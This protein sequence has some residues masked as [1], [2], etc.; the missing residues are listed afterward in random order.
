V[1]TDTG[2]VEQTIAFSGSYV[3]DDGHI[4]VSRA[5][6]DAHQYS[7]DRFVGTCDVC[8]RAGLLPASGELLADV[9]AVNRFVATH[10]HGDTD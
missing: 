6:P 3:S 5:Q 4:R 8:A 10:D 7:G 9:H 1:P 2:M